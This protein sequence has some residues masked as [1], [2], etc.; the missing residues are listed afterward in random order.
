M[1]NFQD[2]STHYDS[3]DD[4]SIQL[5]RSSQVISDNT[6]ISDKTPQPPLLCVAQYFGNEDDLY[7]GVRSVQPLIIFLFDFAHQS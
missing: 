2:V 7:G 5:R 4:A 6:V 1:M 3:D